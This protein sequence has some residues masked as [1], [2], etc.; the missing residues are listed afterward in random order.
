[1]ILQKVEILANMQYDAGAKVVYHS[2][3]NTGSGVIK[4]AKERNRKR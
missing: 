4:A 3:G 1:M 2:A